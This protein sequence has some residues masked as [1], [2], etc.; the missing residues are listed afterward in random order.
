MVN[1]S[2]SK[3]FIQD[4]WQSIIRSSKE[5]EKFIIELMFTLGNINTT[6]ISSKDSPEN[7]VQE[8]ARNSNYIFYKFSKNVNITKHSKAWWNNE[9]STKLN[10][11]HLFKLLKDWKKF[12]RFVKQAKYSFFDK[13]I[14][15]I[16]S[17]NKR[18]WDLMNWV[19]KCK[20]PAIKALWYNR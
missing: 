13:K 5:E 15:E 16:T 12:K 6:D 7:V 2:I 11:Y 8:Y 19:K 9:C 1:I 14:Q 4:R 18:P 20:L 10:T 3:K 17:K